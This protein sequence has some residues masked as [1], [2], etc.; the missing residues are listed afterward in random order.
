M[1][2]TI[3][4]QLVKSLI[5]ESVKNETFLKGQVDKAADQR[6]ITVAYHEQAGNETYQERLLNRALYTNLSELKTQLSDYLSTS[7]HTSADNNIDSHEEGDIITLF[8]VVS[9]RFNKGYTDPLAKL[10]G[11]YIEDAMLVDW[12]KP[13]NEK[14][15]AIYAQFLEKDLASIKRCFNKTAPVAPVVPYTTILK[16]TGTAI[17]LEIGERATV[18]YEISDGAIDDIECRVEDRH[19]IDVGRSEKGFLLIGK[20]RGHTYIQLYSRH[21]EELKKTLH[22]FITNH[23]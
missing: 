18:T 5:I 1:N 3:Q 22:V 21:N 20:Q 7:G 16:T 17:E 23:K 19:L 10:C 11:K 13:I 12:W 2:N 15:S 6:A 9:D 14:Q 8:L 4:L